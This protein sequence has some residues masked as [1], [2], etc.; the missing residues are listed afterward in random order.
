M[1]YLLMIYGSERNEQAMG[2]EKIGQIMAAFMAYT[3]AMKKEG[4]LVG[5]NCLRPADTATTVRV[6]DGKTH[7][8]NGP[9]AETRAYVLRIKRYYGRERHPYDATVTEP[10]PELWRFRMVSAPAP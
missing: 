9:Y 7:V 5:S 8:L 1:Q 4:V 6:T 10:S 3:E 2:Q